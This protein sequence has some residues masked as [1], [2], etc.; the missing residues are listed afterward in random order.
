[1][2]HISVGANLVANTPTTLYTVPKGYTANLTLL[3]IHNST[4]GSKHITATWHYSEENINVKIFDQKTL[5]SKD[6]LQLD[7]LH[8]V[9]EE[10]DY[11]LLTSEAASSISVIATLELKRNT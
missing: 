3:Y 11:L 2:K 5:S 1:M 8:I 6:Y 4:N 7:T 10:H 9:M